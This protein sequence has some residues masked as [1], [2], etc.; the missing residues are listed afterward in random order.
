MSGGNDPPHTLTSSGVTPLPIGQ[1]PNDT[2]KTV[3]GNPNPYLTLKKTVEDPILVEVSPG[4]PG[5]EMQTPDFVKNNRDRLRAILHGLE[6]E[7]HFGPVRSQVNFEATPS[8]VIQT[9]TPGYNI[10]MMS[11]TSGHTIST[12]GSSVPPTSSCPRF[13]SC[14]IN[15]GHLPQVSMVVSPTLDVLG[16]L[17]ASQEPRSMDDDLTAPYQPNYLAELSNFKP[18]MPRHPC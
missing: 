10:L 6:R 12:T 14:P 7:E 5:S 16:P 3:V 8:N 2:R 13:V 4:T 9:G 15:N 11:S 18:R 17:R 1:T